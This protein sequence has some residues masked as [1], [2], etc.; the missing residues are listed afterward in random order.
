V[1]FNEFPNFDI[2]SRWSK[3]VVTGN[4]PKGY[5]VNYW[6]SR[7]ELDIV[8]HKVVNKKVILKVPN[9][10]PLVKND[11]QGKAYDTFYLYQ[12]TEMLTT[13]ILKVDVNS[14]SY[15]SRSFG[16]KNYSSE[17]SFVTFPK[18]NEKCWLINVVYD[19]CKIS[20]LCI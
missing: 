19:G 14:G 4:P 10:W 3:D 2:F 8:K 20:L 16:E 15:I 13:D 6:I 17:P 11:L 9:E 18:N 7:Y 1:D 12:R 5:D